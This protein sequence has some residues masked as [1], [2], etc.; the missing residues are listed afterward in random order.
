MSGWVR[1]G[2]ADAEASACPVRIHRLHTKTRSLLPFIRYVIGVHGYGPVQRFCK[3]YGH[4]IETLLAPVLFSARRYVFET[5]RPREAV[6]CKYC[7][8]LTPWLLPLVFLF[9]FRLHVAVN[10]IW[11][12]FAICE[13]QFEC[14]EGNLFHRL[15]TLLGKFFEPHNIPREWRV[16]VRP[17]EAYM[18][19][20]REWR[21]LAPIIRN[22][23][24]RY[25]RVQRTHVPSTGIRQD[26]VQVASIYFLQLAKMMVHACIDM[27]RVSTG[28]ERNL[29]SDLV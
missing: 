12:D 10:H 26:G 23:R 25:L 22:R 20:P 13:V 3:R 29:S 5:V 27:H 19:Y 7:C 21:A 9:G 18:G 1:D 16:A 6:S 14:V 28:H 8:K 2:L 15:A 17:G 24:K 4:S 11:L